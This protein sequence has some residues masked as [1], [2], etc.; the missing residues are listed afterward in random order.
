MNTCELHILRLT[1]QVIRL[2]RLRVNFKHIT[3]LLIITFLVMN[4]FV[5][6]Q[7]AFEHQIQPVSRIHRIQNDQTELLGFIF[8]IIII[9]IL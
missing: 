4:I 5:I 8:I 2:E 3:K 7:Y 9:I 6:D 1:T